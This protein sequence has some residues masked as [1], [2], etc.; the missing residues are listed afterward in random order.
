MCRWN[1]F[2]LAMTSLTLSATLHAAPLASQ[3]ANAKRIAANPTSPKKGE[4]F[5]P[6]T[7]RV[8]GNKVRL[9]VQPDLEG[10]I[11]RQVAKNDLLLI[12]GEEGEF[13]VVQPPKDAK[14]YVFR[15][16]ILDNVVEASRVNIRL[17]PHV[18]GPIIG[19]LQA[20]DKIQGQVCAMN[21]KWLEIPTPPSTRFYVSKEFIANAG[22]P[23]YLASMEKRKSQVEELLNTALLNADSESKKQYEEMSPQ[24]VIE[25]F[26]SIIRGYSDF[27]EAVARAKE[28]LTVFKDSYLLKKIA[29][30]EAKTQL[31]SEVKDELLAR[32][33]AEKQELFSPQPS[34][35]V[36]RTDKE[37]TDIPRFW[38]GLEESLYLSWTAFHSGR[39]IDDFYAEQ[40]A[41]ASILVGTI[42]VYNHPVKNP[43]GDFI[44]RGSDSPIAY[45]YST[46]VDLEKYIGKE[47]TLQVSPRPNNHFAFP[48]YFVLGIE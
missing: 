29:Y 31:S 7:G 33:K 44:L 19:Q 11:F 9:R 42:E 20:G 6:F 38:D 41:N 12:V 21:H 25:Q 22:G 16:Y 2:V 4:A 3:P 35:I 48:A 1:A 10:H 36:K 32:H 23:E 45:L 17:E 28:G 5:K 46:V 43:P 15:S 47:V 30:L 37:M 27:P 14:A 40:K 13:Y 26:Q 24:L 39:K 8:I 18:D 34:V